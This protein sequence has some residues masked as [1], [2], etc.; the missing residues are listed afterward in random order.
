LKRLLFL[1][2]LLTNL[3]LFSQQAIEYSSVENFLKLPPDRY[4]GEMAGVAVNS[5]GHIRFVSWEHD[6][7]RLRS[8]RIATARVRC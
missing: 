3:P 5:K 8:R 7:T 1:L 6:R 2:F 4:L